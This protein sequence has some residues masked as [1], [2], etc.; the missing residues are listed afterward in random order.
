[1]AQILLSQKQK[2]YSKCIKK[3]AYFRKKR[4]G[5]AIPH[6]VHI[7]NSVAL[8]DACDQL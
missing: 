6:N 1:M 5:C 4:V 8:R 7:S 2:L 3:I